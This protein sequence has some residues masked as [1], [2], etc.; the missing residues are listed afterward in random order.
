MLQKVSTNAPFSTHTHT[1]FLRAM[2]AA[3]FSSRRTTRGSL[4]LPPDMATQTSQTY[5]Q[6]CAELAATSSVRLR[7]VRA[8]ATKQLLH[9]VILLEDPALVRALLKTSTWFAREALAAAASVE[10][11][12]QPDGTL[13][14]TFC[15]ACGDEPFELFPL[16]VRTASGAWRLL[17]SFKDPDALDDDTQ[18]GW[19]GVLVRLCDIPA[20]ALV[21]AQ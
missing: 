7:D 9:C 4:A 18:V 20:E 5:A 15:N 1:S 2:A 6:L 14:G 3:S 17:W 21:R 12:K 13:R 19:N 11:R 8:L 16:H 10:L